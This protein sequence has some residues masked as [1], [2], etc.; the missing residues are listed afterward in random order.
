MTYDIEINTSTIC[1]PPLETRLHLLHHPRHRSIHIPTDRLPHV[2]MNCRRLDTGDI[3][4]GEELFS[5]SIALYGR[6]WCILVHQCFG[7]RPTHQPLFACYRST[8]GLWTLALDHGPW[9][10]DK[11]L[12]YYHRQRYL[13][14][15]AADPTPILHLEIS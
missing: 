2:A 13:D 12:Q 1:W 7:G 10:M 6:H 3:P 8:F 15:I 14:F 11:H 9:T 4:R 5:L